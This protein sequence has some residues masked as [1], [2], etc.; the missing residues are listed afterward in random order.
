MTEI[1]S[2]NPKT[3]KKHGRFF[4]KVLDK[5]RH[6]NEEKGMEISGP[7]DF[8]HESHIGW[9]K[10]NGFE[11]KNIPP[12]WRQLFQAAGIKKKD[13][14]N[15]ETVQFI[16]SVIGENINN[17]KAGITGGTTTAP[18][19]QTNI[20]QQQ[21]QQQQTI[22]SRAPPPP[23]PSST[24]K[25]G[26]QRVPPPKPG[27][28]IRPLPKHHQQINK[29]LPQQPYKQMAQ[30]QPPLQQQQQQTY[31]TRGKLPTTIGGKPIP[32]H[33]NF[34]KPDDE[35]Q[36]QQ[37]QQPPQQQVYNSNEPLIQQEFK[38]QYKLDEPLQPTQK[39]PSP[40]QMEPVMQSTSSGVQQYVYQ[41]QNQ[42]PQEYTFQGDKPQ[43][44]VYQSS[45][46]TQ[47]PQNL[48]G[49]NQYYQQKPQQQQQQ[50]TASPQR[51]QPTPP[52]RQR[53]DLPQQP[54]QT[55]LQSPPPPPLPTTKR[56][57]LPPTPPPTQQR[58]PV[59]QPPIIQR[60]A[61]QPQVIID[62]VE[63]DVMPPPPPP[64]SE[65][66]AHIPVAPVDPKS[67]LPPAPSIQ[68]PIEKPTPISLNNSSV[69][70]PP[71]PPPT[72]PVPPAISKPASVPQT[73]MPPMDSSR[74]N[75]MDSIRGFGGAS[76][77]KKVD[78]NEPLP[79]LKELQLGE[80]GN[81]S[82]VDTL[83]AAMA[84]RRGNLGEND[85]DDD[86]DDSDWENN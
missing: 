40:Q 3:K 11:I 31:N 53:R 58:I 78:P 68:S 79:D 63:G 21:Q 44:Y 60:T 61:Q 35:P 33:Q 28:E 22:R 64:M 25:M 80:S 42:K 5:T 45:Q 71:P 46:Q 83:A 38:S 2:H 55:K 47:Q 74:S 18:Y 23:P 73:S 7:T 49:Y 9:D 1:D 72:A 13:L 75:L 70:P 59:V 30:Q 85:D 43:Q 69:V 12:E 17:Q 77:L 66:L 50:V 16:Y 10:E 84:Q 6:R 15:P 8:K 62:K 86:E 67:P 19:Q 37:L 82:L 29:P 34:M 32:I 4:Q 36:Q 81:R 56:P 65:Q 26:G 51:K 48:E 57:G 76:H 20:P 27:S 14:K 39:R 41:Q 24:Q 54:S 52:P